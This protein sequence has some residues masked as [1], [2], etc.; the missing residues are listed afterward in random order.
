MINTP[1]SINSINSKAATTPYLQS[2]KT[3]TVRL[4]L[5]LPKGIRI[6]HCA[7]LHKDEQETTINQYKNDSLW[8]Y[9]TSDLSKVYS[10]GKKI[11]S[12]QIDKNN[13]KAITVNNEG[14]IIA[15]S[16]RYKR[17]IRK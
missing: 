3:K 15:L 5:D 12:G 13:L 6:N 11:V 10:Y 8:E 14:R 9:Y 4:Y 2:G 16:F 7:I 1:A 17:L